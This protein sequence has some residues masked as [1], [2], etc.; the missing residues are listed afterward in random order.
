MSG[1]RG[2]YGALADISMTFL[3]EAG[4]QQV[5]TGYDL[6]ELK[7]KWERPDLPCRLILPMEE[8]NAVSAGVP[9]PMS[10]GST[11][12]L[13]L[14]TWNVVDLMLWKEVGQGRGLQDHLPDM[15]RYAGQY[16]EQI[17]NHTNPMPHMQLARVAPNIGVYEFPVGT[18][19]K[20][21]GV[22]VQ[23]SFEEIINP[24]G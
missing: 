12:V 2:L 11:G 20:Y 1:V 21:Y 18:D 4:A 14:M 6:H 13:G 10:V 17:M 23:L 24:S 22:E 5:V 7:E 16:I 9:E 19:R 15:V 8:Y 3:T